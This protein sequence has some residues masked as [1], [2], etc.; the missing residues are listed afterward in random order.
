MKLPIIFLIIYWICASC[1]SQERIQGQ[2]STEM[3][4]ILAGTAGYCDKLRQAAFHYFCTEKVVEKSAGWVSRF[5]FDYQLLKNE[6][7]IQEQRILISKRKVHENEENAMATLR[8][9][10][11]EK[12]V[13]AP[14]D[15]FARE[16]QPL[17]QYRFIAYEKKKGARCA[18]IEVLPRSQED[19][20]IVHGQAWIDTADHSVLM[21]KVSPRSVV[22]YEKMQAIARKLVAKLFLSLEIS[23]EKKHAGMR[24]P[25][26]IVIIERYKGGQ[27]HLNPKLGPEG[28]ERNR[29][30]YRYKKYRFFEVGVQA[31][32]KLQ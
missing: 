27:L 10:F 16:R 31:T 25:D 17:Y 26:V 22:G 6:N 32:E 14:V 1:F 20:R 4:A 11:V 13:F 28:W 19:A 5:T 15:L 30:E 21:I 18:V 23:F 7:K 2:A 29:S 12:A 24:F 8:A 9:F 3:A